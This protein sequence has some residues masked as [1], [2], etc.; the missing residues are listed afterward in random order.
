MPPILVPV[1][2]AASGT[3]TTLRRYS[4][5]L[6]EELGYK[7]SVQVTTTATIGEAARTVIAAEFRD[8]EYDEDALG[9]WWVYVVDGPLAGTQRRILNRGFH[10][11]EAAFWV[12]RPFPTPIT[13]GTTIR[14]TSPL[15][16]KRYMGIKGLDQLVNEALDRILVE[17]RIPLVGTGSN[18]VTLN[19][20]S[21]LTSVDQTAGVYD[22]LQAVYATDATD[23]SPYAYR[24][25]RNGADTTIVTGYSYA[26]GTDFQLAVRVQADRL[27][28][29][30]SAWAY[31]TTPG[32]VN[33]TDQAAA[34]E[35][36]VRTFGMV[37]ALQWLRTKALTDRKMAQD[38]RDAML[39]LV[40]TR[41]PTYVRTAN[42]LTVNAFPR[43]FSM[44]RQSMLP[45]LVAISPQSAPYS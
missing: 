26:S 10:G 16:V 34:P 1:G 31:A 18:A 14:I 15:P 21:F 12:S 44:P 29:D 36:W 23:L 4:D 25:E 41:M 5:V 6:A 24:I 22:R 39:A 19:A 11:S 8:D 40:Q 45:S 27:I 28:Y 3:G 20:Y 38:E 9:G 35:E 32:L 37:K 30:G 7:D 43:P 2:A 13:A 17:A 42:D 33:D